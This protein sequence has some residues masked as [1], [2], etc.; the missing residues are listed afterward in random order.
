MFHNTDIL[1]HVPY[2]DK[3]EAKQNG[4]FYDGDLKSW[5][6][7]KG[8][9]HKNYDNLINKYGQPIKKGTKIYLNVPYDDK[10]DAKEKG[11]WYDADKKAWF[12]WNDNP[13]KEILTELY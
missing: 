13:H 4:A 9:K 6:I 7:P 10:D 11:A 8:E 5:Y 1:I 12:T 2:A 3:D